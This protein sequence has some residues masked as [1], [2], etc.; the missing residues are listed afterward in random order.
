MKKQYDVAKVKRG[1]SLHPTAWELVK[2]QP[3]PE[4]A[5]DNWVIEQIVNR[6]LGFDPYARK[7]HATARKS[8]VREESSDMWGAE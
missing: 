3:R 7:V 2:Q 4:G 1:V 5:G 8:G 6:A